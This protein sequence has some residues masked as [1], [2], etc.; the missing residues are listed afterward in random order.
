MEKLISF[1]EKL[2]LY[3]WLGLTIIVVLLLVNRSLNPDLK[4]ISNYD[5]KDYA[6]ITLIF[7]VIYFALRLFTS[8]KDRNE[9]K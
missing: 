9:T 6:I 8:R 4:G 3:I 5:L 1:I 7:A 2:I